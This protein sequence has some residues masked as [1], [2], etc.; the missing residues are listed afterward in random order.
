MQYVQ[1][2][3]G[4]RKRLNSDFVP[5]HGGFTGTAGRTSIMVRPS[6]TQ[7]TALV[8]WLETQFPQKHVGS[9]HLANPRA[10]L[11][12]VRE[13]EQPTLE[14]AIA[15]EAFER[16]STARIIG[17]LESQQAVGRLRGNPTERLYL[18]FGLE[19]KVSK[20]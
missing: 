4:R 16:S 6:S 3:R 17:A 9:R 13:R 2:R 14:L 12:T 11:F 19:L 15:N 7:V 1:F 8:S 18:D 5:Q 20:A 10:Q